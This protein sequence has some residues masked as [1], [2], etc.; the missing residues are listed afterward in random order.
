MGRDGNIEIQIITNWRLSYVFR[1][2]E[3]SKRKQ[4]YC[5]DSPVVILSLEYL[6][7]E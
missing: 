1:E 4:S 3:F 2:L 7:E 6:V 5:S